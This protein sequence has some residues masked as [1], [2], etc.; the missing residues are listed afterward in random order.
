MRFH[1]DFPPP[2]L[3]VTVTQLADSSAETPVLHRI[4]SGASSPFHQRRSASAGLNSA[5]LNAPGGFPLLHE[6]KTDPCFLSAGFQRS[7]TCCSSGVLARAGAD[8]AV[9]MRCAD[10]Q[11]MHSATWTKITG[12][13]AALL[14]QTQKKK[15]KSLENS[16]HR[17]FS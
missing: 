13:K 11:L 2:A 5:G 17:C 9:D 15:K 1:E 16:G 12:Q 4:I 10:L 3:N 6:L 14:F 8:Q 7:E